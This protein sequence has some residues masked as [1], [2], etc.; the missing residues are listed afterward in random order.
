MLRRDFLKWSL[1]G[2]LASFFAGAWAWSKEQALKLLDV[3]GKSKDPAQVAAYGTLVQGMGYVADAKK[4]K[5]TPRPTPDGKTMPA[6]SQYCTT[7]ALLV[8]Q[9]LVNTGKNGECQLA[10]G[11][12]VHGLGY[13]NTFS[14]STTA[15]LDYKP[16]GK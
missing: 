8:D 10:R 1:A 3:T 13:C 7:C 12:L 9:S 11:V 14:P 2:T 5:R 4:G 6:E 16:G 15:K